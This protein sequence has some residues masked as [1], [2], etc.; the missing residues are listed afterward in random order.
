MSN[1]LI[2]KAE[3]LIV[4]PLLFTMRAAGVLWFGILAVSMLWRIASA[5][6]GA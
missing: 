1:A 3:G 5:F 4:E 2:V 6:L